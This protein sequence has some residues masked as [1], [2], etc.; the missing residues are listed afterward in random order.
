VLLGM[1]PWQGFTKC[2]LVPIVEEKDKRF[3]SKE[4]KL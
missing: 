1:M 3:F 4:L 2:G